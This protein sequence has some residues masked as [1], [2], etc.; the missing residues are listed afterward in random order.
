MAVDL[1]TCES[2]ALRG[3]RAT[4]AAAKRAAQAAMSND[5][6]SAAQSQTV[7]GTAA[8]AKEAVCRVHGRATAERWTRV[9]GKTRIVDPAAGHRVLGCG[10]T[11]A[12]AW[13]DAAAKLQK[14][15]NPAGKAAEG[16]SILSCAP[17]V[18]HG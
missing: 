7:R 15:G 18:G 2:M 4:R 17:G 6:S 9:D 13:A 14:P 1:E 16:T 11:A 12:Q 3:A 5:P 10:A 8:T